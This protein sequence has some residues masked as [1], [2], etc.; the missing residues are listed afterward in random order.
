MKNKNNSKKCQNAKKKNC[1]GILMLYE[2]CLNL[3]N[4]IIKKLSK[5]SN[6]I[7]FVSC[8]IKTMY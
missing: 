3:L 2:N 5:L 7:I 6:I 8:Y 4:H 1:Y